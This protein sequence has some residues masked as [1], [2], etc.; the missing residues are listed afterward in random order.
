MNFDKQIGKSHGKD[1]MLL[2]KGWY[3]QEKYETTKDAL[4]EYYYKNYGNEDIIGDYDAINQILLK[5]A[6]QELLT[7]RFQRLFI[8][9]MFETDV[10]D[11]WKF[12]IKHMNVIRLDYEEELYYRMTKFLRALQTNNGDGNIYI[13]TSD[14]WLKE[15]GLEVKKD[16][17][18]VLA[19]QII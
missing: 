13:D 3:N 1:I 9:C 10:I 8:S 5:P 18:N 17:H 4:N 6:I 2:C 11:Y 16:D 14:Y 19:E 7:E 15:N 12:D